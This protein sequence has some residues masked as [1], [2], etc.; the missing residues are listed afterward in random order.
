MQTCQFA[1][2]TWISVQ[3]ITVVL[4]LFQIIRHF[5]NFEE[6]KHLKFDQNYRENYKNL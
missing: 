2:A 3:A 5:K 6:S 1:T 4:P